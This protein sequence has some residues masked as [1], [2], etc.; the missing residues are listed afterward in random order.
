M[1]IIEDQDDG[2]SLSDL[3]EK[4]REA[5]KEAKPRVLGVGAGQ[6]REPRQFLIQLRDDLGNHCGPRA[7]LGGE[8]LCWPPLDNRT[9]DLYPRP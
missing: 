4:R 1:Q 5:V 9:K 7:K 2:L 8:D 6:G 3:G